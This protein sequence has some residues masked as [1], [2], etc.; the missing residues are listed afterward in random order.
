MR[1]HSLDL[2]AEGPDKPALLHLGIDRFHDLGLF[3]LALKAFMDA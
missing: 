2:E 1:K 3:H